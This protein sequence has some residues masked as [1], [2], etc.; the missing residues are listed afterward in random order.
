MRRL[1]LVRHGQSIWNAERRI[2]GQG[3][4]GLSETGKAQAEHVADW[5]ARTFPD[6]DIVSSDIQRCVETTEPI[7]S[8]LGVEPRLDPGVRERDFGEW[9]GSLVAEIEERDPERF[10]RWRDGEDVVPE[11]GGESGPQ[12]AARTLETLERVAAEREEGATVVVT[13]GG[14]VWHGTHAF[15]DLAEGTLG[16]VANTSVTELLVDATWGRRLNVWNQ[17]SHLPPELVTW[18]RPADGRADRR[19]APPVGR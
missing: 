15:L 19:S 18:L 6:A 7:A 11:V 10:A 9:T 2:Q 4:T 13:H 17:T 14:P 8:A 5:L 16:G 1:V 12:L 3:G